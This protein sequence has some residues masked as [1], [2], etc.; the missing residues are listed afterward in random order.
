MSVKEA[1]TFEQSLAFD[2]ILKMRKWDER[3]KN[4]SIPVDE[5]ALKRYKK[6]CLELLTTT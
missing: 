5:D 1:F 4:P 6:M 3:A 2:A